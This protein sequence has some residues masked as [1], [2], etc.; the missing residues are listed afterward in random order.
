MIS[1]L[2]ILS[3]FQQHKSELIKECTDFREFSHCQPHYLFQFDLL[4]QICHSYAH[5]KYMRKNYTGITMTLPLSTERLDRLPLHLNRWKGKMSIV[6]QLKEEELEIVAKTVSALPLR[7]IRFTFYVIAK[8]EEGVSRCVFISMNRTQVHY[9][10]CL[11]INVLRNL[12]IE[13][14][15]STHFMVIDGDGILTSEF[16]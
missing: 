13:T 11:V 9:D 3:F 12:A 14:I 7:S 8:Q 4:P 15:R 16:E 2:A 10:T 6:I 1:I 5:E